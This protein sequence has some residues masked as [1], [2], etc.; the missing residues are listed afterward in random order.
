VACI[1]DPIEV[2]AAP[3]DED[4]ELGI[5]GGEDRPQHSNA[6][7]LETPAFDPRDHVLRNT[8]A[9]RDVRLAEP[10]ALPQHSYDPA[11]PKVVHR[12]IFDSCAWRPI[13]ADPGSGFGQARL[14]Q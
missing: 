14:D 3:P 2:T 6:H 11:E 5:E 7:R 8:G 4:D 13:A 12:S 10:E 9:I 1:D